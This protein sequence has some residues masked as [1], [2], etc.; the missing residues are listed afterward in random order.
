MENLSILTHTILKMNIRR[1]GVFAYLS[2]M[3]MR[4]R[5]RR[6]PLGFSNKTFSCICCHLPLYYCSISIM[7]ICRW[8]T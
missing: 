6:K 8:H 5:R 7:T 3:M 1:I 4:R 2:M